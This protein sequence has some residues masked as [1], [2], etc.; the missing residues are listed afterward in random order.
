[1]ADA[2]GANLRFCPGLPPLC[3]PT[4][5]QGFDLTAPQNPALHTDRADDRQ[6]EGPM[7]SKTAL[8]IVDVQNDFSPAAPGRA[9]GDSV[10]NRST[11]H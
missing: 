4:P 2:V 5:L 7:N 3:Q 1:M 11:G 6:E 10:S 8:M 9:P